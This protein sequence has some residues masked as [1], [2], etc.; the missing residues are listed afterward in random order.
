MNQLYFEGGCLCG[1]IRYRVGGEPIT[2][3]IC[4]CRTCRGISSAPILPFVTFPLER[5]ELTRGKPVDFQSSPPVTRNFC[6]RCGTPLTYRHRDHADEIDV[7][8]GSLD[9]PEAFP[10][11]HHIW[12]SHKLAWV[13]LSDGLPAYE[14]TRSET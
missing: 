14:T 13:Q 3:G 12:V 5:F 1:A 6:G 4:H 11:S 10:P 8:T 7:M 2:S 9:N